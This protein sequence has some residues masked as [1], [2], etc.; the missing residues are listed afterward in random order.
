M[1]IPGDGVTL[2]GSVGAVGDELPP[3]ATYPKASRSKNT[4]VR[5]LFISD[6][7]SVISNRAA[8]A[9]LSPKT[10]K[11]AATGARASSSKFEK[12]RNA[13]S[14]GGLPGLK[15]DL[16]RVVIALRNKQL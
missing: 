9:S 12:E 3:Q 2:D 6:L 16:K 11:P 5:S 13:F 15:A 4:T 10:S 14:R 1:G 8:T 7:L